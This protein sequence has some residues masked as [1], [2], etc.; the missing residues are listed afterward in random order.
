MIQHLAQ[1]L[2]ATH[3]RNRARARR[4]SRYTK[5]KGKKMLGRKIWKQKLQGCSCLLFFILLF[6]S[7][8][9][10]QGNKQGN[11]KP[12]PTPDGQE[13]DEG[14]VISVSTSEV[15]LPV[16]VR[17]AGGRLVTTLTREN[18]RVFEDGRKH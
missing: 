2:R 17:D 7:L 14:D 11:A 18:F 8:A 12:A 13:I 4:R 15:L 1:S 6:S 10:A 5:T 3:R 9:Q 16:T